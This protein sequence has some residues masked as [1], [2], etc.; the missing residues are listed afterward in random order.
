MSKICKMRKRCSVT[1]IPPLRSK[2]YC[3]CADADL[4]QDILKTITM[5]TE[6]RHGSNIV[7]FP[8]ASKKENV[9][10]MKK[11][12]LLYMQEAAKRVC[13]ASHI[14]QSDDELF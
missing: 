11:I 3:A 13:L 8:V 9:S 14:A 12:Q 5:I 4:K 2:W 7:M 1:N 6:N 10:N